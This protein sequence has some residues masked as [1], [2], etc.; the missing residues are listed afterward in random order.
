MQM[1]CRPR[2]NQPGSWS[3][4]GLENLE[5]FLRFATRSNGEREREAESLRVGESGVGPERPRNPGENARSREA[6]L[7]AARVDTPGVDRPSVSGRLGGLLESHSRLLRL[8]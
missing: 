8:E 1:E 4:V 6:I 5:A 7:S 2:R 3:G